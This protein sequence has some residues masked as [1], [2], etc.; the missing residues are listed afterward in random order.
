VRVRKLMGYW[1]VQ[2]RVEV[3]NHPV[4]EYVA[5]YGTWAIAFAVAQVEASPDEWP[6]HREI[7]HHMEACS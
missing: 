2:R 7:D 4:W 1:V 3:D 5:S 6:F